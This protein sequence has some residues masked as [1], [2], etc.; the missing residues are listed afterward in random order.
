MVSAR[1]VATKIDTGQID[2]K[3]MF[4][5]TNDQ[6]MNQV[7]EQMDENQGRNRQNSEK[8]MEDAVVAD[9]EQRLTV[10]VEIN[11]VDISDASDAN[12]AAGLALSC[13][14]TLLNEWIKEEMI[15]G[16]HD[17]QGMVKVNKWKGVEEWTKI[18]KVVYKK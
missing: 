1:T 13:M 17:M 8:D 6:E 3:N 11:H 18:P 16:V 4:N 12:E 2:I 10:E 7:S 5:G 14:V 15:Q 9:D